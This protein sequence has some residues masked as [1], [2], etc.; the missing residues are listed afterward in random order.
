MNIKC[1]YG[2][3]PSRCW[4]YSLG[5]DPLMPPRKCPYNCIYCPIMPWFYK[6]T[7]QPQLY[8]SPD[9]IAGE[10]EEFIKLNGCVF[11]TIM[12]WGMGDPLLNFHTPLIIEKIREISSD[13]GCSNQIILRT[14][15]YL[16]S[17]KWAQPIFSKV[18]YVLIPL[19]VVGEHRGTL[20][21]PIE[22]ATTNFLKTVIRSLPRYA[23]R[24]ILAEINLFR[25]EWF[26]PSETQYLLELAATLKNIGIAKVLIKSIDRPGRTT[27][28]KPLR[29]KQID[30]TRKILEEEGLEAKI[31]SSKPEQN[32]VLAGDVEEQIYNHILRKPLSVKEIIMVYGN[33]GIVSA[34]R[35]V[36]QGRLEKINW[37]S[38]IYF[39]AKKSLDVFMGG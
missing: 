7:L 36:E 16:L 5:I 25:N 39:I 15:G 22:R 4:G 27:G 14:T 8:V 18:D 6:K 30:K 31:C 13:Y 23:R 12:I 2:P 9:R 38:E 26:N 24:K 10:I 34:E 28:I 17:E 35:L 19:D 11:N 3:H 32:I 29:G 20:V 37:F 21:E 1:I 33:E